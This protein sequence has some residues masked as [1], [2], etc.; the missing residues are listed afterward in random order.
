M[1]TY[2]YI[3]T[4]ITVII[5]K[6]SIEPSMMAHGNPS[7]QES[8]TRRISLSLRLILTWVI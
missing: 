8:K 3:H 5:I 6:K 1:Y 2:I 4:I 7:T